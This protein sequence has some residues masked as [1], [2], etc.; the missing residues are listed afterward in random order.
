MDEVDQFVFVMIPDNVPSWSCYVSIVLTRE[1]V[2]HATTKDI[3]IIWEKKKRKIDD[4]DHF[5]SFHYINLISLK[6]YS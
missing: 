6:W 1:Q 4:K 2:L 3:Y 5:L